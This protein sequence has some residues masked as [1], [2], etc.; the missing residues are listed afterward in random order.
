MKYFLTKRVFAFKKRIAK[1]SGGARPSNKGV[2]GRSSTRAQFGLKIRGP[3]PGSATENI[4]TFRKISLLKA[5]S[6]NLPEERKQ[7]VDRLLEIVS[8]LVNSWRV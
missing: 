3:S 4:L 2:G 6:F 7:I 5:R 8:M 1:I